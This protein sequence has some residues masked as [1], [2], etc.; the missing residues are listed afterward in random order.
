[1]FGFF[2]KG[3][4]GGMAMQAFAVIKGDIEFDLRRLRNSAQILHINMPESAELGVHRAKHGVVRVAGV[5]GMI[6]W[7]KVVLKMR[8]R[9]ITGVIH[10]EA[11]PEVVH[12]M[13]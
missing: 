10:I 7:Y 12:Y 9:Q 5:A 3:P 2:F 8:R 11:L 6:A 4:H 13:T 1:M